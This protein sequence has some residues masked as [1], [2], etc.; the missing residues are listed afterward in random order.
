MDFS[1]PPEIEEL[2]RSL[3]DF[4]E[5]EVRPLEEARLD[6][7]TD[8]VPTELRARVRR[9][10]AELGFYAADFPE[11]HG[12]SG[13]SQVGMVALRDEAYGSGLRLGGSVCAGPEG[14][15]GI[16]LEATDEQK[17]RYLAPLV[18]AEVSTAFALTEPEAGSDAQNIR[19]SAAREGGEWVLNG[20]KHFI[21]N[22]RE[23]DF[24]IVLA[25]NDREKRAHGGITAFIV[26]KGT[27]GFSVG[28][29]QVG[30]VDDEPQVELVFEDCRVS[31]EQV[32]GGPE[33]VGRGFYQAMRFLGTGRLQIAAMS[34]GLAGFALGLG[35]EHARSR[36]AFGRPIGSF[37]YVQGHLVDSL[38]ELRASRHLTN[39]CA[40]RYD[41]GEPVIRESSITKLYATEMVNRV[42]Y[43]MTQVFGGMGWMREVPLERLYRSVR[44]F[45]LF[46]GTSEIQRYILA[47]TLGL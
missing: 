3:R 25:A 44:G 37:Q 16:L 18:R 13:L 31:E 20:R 43:R 39:E 11:E 5:R 6:P 26:E 47:K 14:P 23:A 42:A 24:V 1:L 41:R 4:L 45:T 19:T 10:S 33:K 21:T 32:L 28:R 40:W 7:D 9:R 12:G 17:K 34:N 38:V 22:G 35:V 36:K 29:A 2:R 30:M 27:P 46:E 15:T 8:R